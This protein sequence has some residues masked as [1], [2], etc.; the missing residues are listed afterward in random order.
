M[1]PFILLLETGLLENHCQFLQRNLI[2]SVIAVTYVNIHFNMTK[3]W[4]IISAVH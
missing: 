4:R 3:C 1:E 2:L